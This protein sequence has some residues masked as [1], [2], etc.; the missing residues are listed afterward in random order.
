MTTDERNQGCEK[1]S[2][3]FKQ[4]L[5]KGYKLARDMVALEDKKLAEIKQCLN[6]QHCQG[7]TG[8]A[9][10]ANDKLITGYRTKEG[11]C[12]N[13]T[14]WEELYE[15][16]LDPEIL[17]IRVG[18]RHYQCMLSSINK[19]PGKYAGFGGRK[20]IVKVREPHIRG[21]ANTF[22]TCD[23]WTQGTIPEYFREKLPD[24]AEFVNE[25]TETV[26]FDGRDFITCF[27]VKS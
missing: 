15:K 12:L 16:R 7:F 14:H 27:D 6:Y 4:C 11:L 5:E 18:G 23:M 20:F 17:S 13:C 19:P 3:D 25:V 26:V 10:D 9:K 22:Y 8:C 2:E 21:M 24:N 1:H